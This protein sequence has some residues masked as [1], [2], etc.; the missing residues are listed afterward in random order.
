[1]NRRTSSLLVLAA[2]FALPSG[3]ADAPAGE[4]GVGRKHYMDFGCWQCHGTTGA[5]GGWQGPKLAPDLLPY[6]A[7]L[8]QVR[9]PRAQMPHYAAPLLRD[10]DV[11]HI[12]AYLQSIPRGRPARDIDALN[13]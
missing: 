9:K 10:E 11:A 6:V 1:M 5:G 2:L 3:A 12:Y 13:R 4:P 7:F 8:A